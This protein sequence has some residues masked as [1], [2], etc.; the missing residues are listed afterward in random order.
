MK[1]TRWLTQQTTH[2][3]AATTIHCGIRHLTLRCLFTPHATQKACLHNLCKGASQ[4]A[5]NHQ[6]TYIPSHLQPSQVCDSPTPPPSFP[7][8][9]HHSTAWCHCNRHCPTKGMTNGVE[10]PLVLSRLSLTEGRI[11]NYSFPQGQTA[12][13]NDISS[14]QKWVVLVDAACHDARG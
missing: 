13:S 4:R 3:L 10:S 1:I 14:R 5:C 7:D 12:F 2:R 8:Q 9:P 11:S 6:P